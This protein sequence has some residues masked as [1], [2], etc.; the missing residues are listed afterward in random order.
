MAKYYEKI[1]EKR[2]GACMFAVCR[3]KISEGIDFADDNGRAV[4]VTGLPFPLYT[5]PKVILKRRYL[6]ESKVVK[7]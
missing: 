3:G 4:I 7:I 2:S 1:K 6:D 5:D